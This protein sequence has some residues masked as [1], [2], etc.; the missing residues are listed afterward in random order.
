MLPSLPCE[1]DSYCFSLYNLLVGGDGCGPLHIGPKKDK[2]EEDKTDDYYYETDTDSNGDYTTDSSSA[3]VAASE[4]V[5]DEYAGKTTAS[6]G[7]GGGGTA[8]FEMWMMAT[9]G[10][11]LAALI[12]INIGQ[13]KNRSANNKHGMQGSVMRRLGVVSAFAEGALPCASEGLCANQEDVEM[14][15]QEVTPGYQLDM[16]PEGV[17]TTP[18]YQVA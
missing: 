8:G 9:A 15:G 3:Q 7:R 1:R 6:G 4:A 16:G 13:R 12:A 11:V 10:A 5:E 18:G 2:C 17:E 14:Q